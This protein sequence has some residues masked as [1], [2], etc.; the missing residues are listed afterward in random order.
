MG[1]YLLTIKIPI[2]A[3]DDPDARMAA[4]DIL[5]HDYV[6][7]LIQMKNAEVKL[8]RLEKGKPPVGRPI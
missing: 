3:Q 8:Q 5:R 4:K 7:A 2:V 1:E 6:Q